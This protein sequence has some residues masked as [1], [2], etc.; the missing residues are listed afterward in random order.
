[1][2]STNGIDVQLLEPLLQQLVDLIGIEA[3]MRMVEVHGG[4]LLN[5]ARKASE[6]AS[7]VALIGREKAGILGRAMGPGRYLIP[8]AL[9]ALRAVRDRQ[10][11]AQLATMS[12]RQVARQ[13]R[14]CE[15]R[16]WQIKASLGT[17]VEDPTPDLFG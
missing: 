5:V 10:I 16:L 1:M 17:P 13:H 3:T 8:K 12:V 7:L 9:P 2:T 6:N 4:T 14:L 11:A 15:R